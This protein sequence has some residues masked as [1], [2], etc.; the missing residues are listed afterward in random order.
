MYI[1][2][3]GAQS[4]EGEWGPGT[5][6]PSG[7]RST[8]I[9]FTGPQLAAPGQASAWSLQPGPAWLFDI[10]ATETAR[11]L[12]GSRHS[13]PKLAEAPGTVGGGVR[14]GGRGRGRRGGRGRT[15]FPEEAAATNCETHG[16]SFYTKLPPPG[17]KS[18]S[19]PGRVLCFSEPGFPV[20]SFPA[21]PVSARVLPRIGGSA[22]SPRAPTCC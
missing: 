11:G 2:V 4:P 13:A 21:L 10:V 15:S 9:T 14:R 17:P 1:E 3:Q 8:F 19:L 12:L 16:S 6:G 7:W 22:V 5:E 18:L 20:T